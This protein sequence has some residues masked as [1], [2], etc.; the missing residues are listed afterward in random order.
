MPGHNTPMMSRLAKKL[1][2]PETH[3]LIAKQLTGC[4]NKSWIPQNIMKAR[5]N[6]P[7]TQRMK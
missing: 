3:C 5:R 1:V 4:H 7:M 6:S 2:M